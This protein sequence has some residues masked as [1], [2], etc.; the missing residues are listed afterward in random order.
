MAD[1]SRATWR[2]E[3]ASIIAANAATKDLDP[4]LVQAVIQV[5]SGGNPWANRYEARYRWLAKW[6]SGDPWPRNRSVL[7]FPSPS[8]V[9]RSTEYQNQKT[10]WG[11]MQIMGGVAREVG[12]RKPFLTELL[13]PAT[14]VQ[15]GCIFL[16]R[17]IK[18]RGEDIR[19]G[20]KRWNGS[21]SYPPKVMRVYNKFR[22]TA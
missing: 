15:F 3:Y 21:A 8:G 2:D 19:A 18:E 14:N 5:E 11:L 6:N 22:D 20:L 4:L 12:F 1:F 9:S 17:C 16:R 7:Q 13:N 10:S